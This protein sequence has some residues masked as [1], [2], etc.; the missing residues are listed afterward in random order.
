MSN[1]GRRWSS[2]FQRDYRV[3]D[4]VFRRVLDLFPFRGWTRRRGQHLFIGDSQRCGFPGQQRRSVGR[5]GGCGVRR[6]WRMLRA[7]ARRRGVCVARI[8][9]WAALRC[10][11]RTRI[12]P[13]GL[14]TDWG[15]GLTGSRLHS[16]WSTA[17]AITTLSVGNL[18]FT[19]QSNLTGA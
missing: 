17:V 10:T 7:A 13:V 6:V 5:S 11:T 18:S 14:G 1:W 8:R 9:R 3:L 19:I 16:R 12:V 4:V 15:G 2:R